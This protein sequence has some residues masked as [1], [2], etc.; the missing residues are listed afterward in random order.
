MYFFEKQS[1]L[2]E[3]KYKK[4]LQYAC[5]REAET[6]LCTKNVTHIGGF[7]RTGKR[8][9]REKVPGCRKLGGAC[10]RKVVQG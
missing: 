3:M 6:K 10:R 5:R 1:V 2:T 8:S 7:G 9:G 4:L